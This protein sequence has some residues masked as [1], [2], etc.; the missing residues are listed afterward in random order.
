MAPLSVLLICILGSS[1]VTTQCPSSE[2]FLS[3]VSL[4]ILTFVTVSNIFCINY[5]QITLRSLHIDN[6]KNITSYLPA[7]YVKWIEGGGG[8]IIP[9]FPTDDYT[10]LRKL[11][12]KL[13]GILIIGGVGTTQKHTI[14]EEFIMN[15]LDILRLYAQQNNPKNIPLWGT[16]DGF[17]NILTAI[18]FNRESIMDQCDAADVSFV[19]S[20]NNSNIATSTMFD[21][22]NTESEYYALNALVVQMMQTNAI[23]FNDHHKGISPNR[24]YSDVYI[25]G[26]LSVLGVSN[27]LNGK[28]FVTLFESR[29][30]LNLNWFGS[31]FHPEDAAFRS[32]KPV[33]HTY[34][35]IIA[36][37]WFAQFFVNMARTSNDNQMSEDEFDE[38]AIYNYEPEHQEDGVYYFTN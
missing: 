2:S 5:T 6:G 10:E 33:N 19:V 17:E 22:A 3:P 15:V 11:I 9:L 35:S 30:E 32:Q 25:N 31:Q 38:R 1:A 34:E 20:F 26:N 36:N 23:A 24:F 7:T 28:P 13:N 37:Q 21:L 4:T 12:P 14:Y 18:S 16:C 29:R 27:D 8:Q